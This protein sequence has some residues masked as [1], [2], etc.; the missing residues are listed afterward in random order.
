MAETVWSVDVVGVVLDLRGV[1]C[2]SHLNSN[3]IALKTSI[4]S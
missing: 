4:I 3:W 2:N 1:L